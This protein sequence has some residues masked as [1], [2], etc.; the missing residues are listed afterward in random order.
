MGTIVLGYVPKPEGEAALVRAVA[1]AKLRGAR[2]IVVNTHTAG[3]FDVK[4]LEDSGVGYEVRNFGSDVDPA[5]ELV[6]IAQENEAELIVIGL[7]R[8]SPVGKLILG[9]S[10]QRILLDAGCAVLAVKA[11]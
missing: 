5:D 2:L 9:S 4:V 10:T 11:G 7:R 1:E 8:R 3:D 6:A